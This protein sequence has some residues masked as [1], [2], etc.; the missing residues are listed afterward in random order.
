METYSIVICP[1]EEEIAELKKQIPESKPLKIGN[2]QGFEFKAGEDKYFAFIGRIGKENI[3]FDIGYLSGLINIKKIYNIG[4][5]GSLVKDIVPLNVVVATKTCYY[6]VD[7]T[8]FEPYVF[9]QMAG[10]KDLY[11]YTDKDDLAALDNL[12]T[13]LTIIKGTIISGDSFAGKDNMSEELLAKFDNPLAVD[14]E[15]GAC[16]QAARRLNVPFTIIR[17]I[18][19]YVLSEDNKSTYEEFIY[20][21]ARRAATVFLH[22]INKDFVEA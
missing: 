9:G 7:V 21:S 5:A 10:E 17:G 4:V 3:G 16:G 12:N 1:M 6:D 22:I 15:S 20:L 11:F 19:D 18:S 14:M 8:H 2:I 13:T